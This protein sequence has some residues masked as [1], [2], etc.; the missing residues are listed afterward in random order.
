MRCLLCH[1]DLN[2]TMTVDFLS[3][4]SSTMILQY[5]T[6]ILQI[7]HGTTV[8]Y[9]NGEIHIH[10]VHILYISL[11]HVCTCTTAKHS[12]NV[13]SEQ[14]IYARGSSSQ[15]N[16]PI[17]DWSDDNNSRNVS[18]ANYSECGCVGGRRGWFISSG[19]SNGSNEEFSGYHR[20]QQYCQY[21]QYWVPDVPRK[22][23]PHY[24]HWKH[25]RTF[26]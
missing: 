20:E 25:R 22:Y 26:Q 5:T 12:C 13:N 11:P 14:F 1:I 16:S 24:L 9:N 15:P 10:L 4:N 17:V 6:A 21:C 7:K 18:A 23:R 19:N 8:R 2:T 3:S